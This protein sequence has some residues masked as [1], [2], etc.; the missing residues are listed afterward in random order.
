MKCR[1]TADL[2]V[3]NVLKT[4]ESIYVMILIKVRVGGWNL[5]VALVFLSKLEAITYRFSI[6]FNKNAGI[7]NR[8]EEK[9]K[10]K[11][12]QRHIVSKFYF[13][14]CSTPTLPKYI[15]KYME[16]CP[17]RPLTIRYAEVVTCF[18]ITS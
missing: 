13:V 7:S 14:D 2:V 1:K 9:N 18:Y 17:I 12:K 15:S 11:K 3:R 8:E 4:D 5:Q 6:H 10:K 16:P